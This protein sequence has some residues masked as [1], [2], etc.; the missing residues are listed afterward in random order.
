MPY[1]FRSLNPLIKKKWENCSL[2]K[3]IT[4]KAILFFYKLV[5]GD[6][7]GMAC[8]KLCSLHTSPTCSV[9]QEAD[10][11]GLQQPGSPAHWLPVGF[12]QLMALVGTK[13]AATPMCH[14]IATA[15][16]WS[17]SLELC[18]SHPNCSVT[19]CWEGG[20]GHDG[21]VYTTE[22][23]KHYKSGLLTTACC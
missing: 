1:S 13:P 12:S 9:L 22:I 5:Y 7:G 4:S 2:E 16:C 17:C 10:L 23:G 6:S 19:S 8:P 11:W 15:M 14:G 18:T 3:V 20:N 21:S